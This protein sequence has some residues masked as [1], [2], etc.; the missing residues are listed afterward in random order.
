MTGIA[1]K[2]IHQIDTGTKDD[3]ACDLFGF[4]VNEYMAKINKTKE[5]VCN[6]TITGF[7]VEDDTD[8]EITDMIALCFMA[9]IDIIVIGF[10]KDISDNI[11]RVRDMVSDNNTLSRHYTEMKDIYENRIVFV[12]KY[13]GGF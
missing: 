2:S 11:K 3:G 5:E 1:L 12:N 9:S 7:V 10:S 4:A 8:Y 13:R 6:H